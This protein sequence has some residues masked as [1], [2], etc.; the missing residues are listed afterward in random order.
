M[1][2]VAVLLFPAAYRRL[3]LTLDGHIKT[4]EQRTIIQ[5][6]GDWYTVV[7]MVSRVIDHASS[8]SSGR[9]PRTLKAFSTTVPI[10]CLYVSVLQHQLTDQ[11]KA[12]LQVCI[13]RNICIKPEQ[14]RFT[15]YTPFHYD[16]TT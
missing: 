11:L 6:Y 15:H 10:S 7:S 4:T 12:V 2:H 3:A 1:P 14:T 8:G 13:N 9:S 5:Q 16:M